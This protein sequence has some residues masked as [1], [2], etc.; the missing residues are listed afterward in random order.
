MEESIV[1]FL[2]CLR[3]QG[4]S[5]ATIIWYRGRLLR[6]AYSLRCPVG[7]IDRN[8]L[9]RYVTH[10]CDRLSPATVEGHL[11]AVNRFFGWCVEEGLLAENPVSAL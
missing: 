10:L 3:R 5:P 8:S 6:C 9:L 11:R 7:E 1:T 4:L 2:F